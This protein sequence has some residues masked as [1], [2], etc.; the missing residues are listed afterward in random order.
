M[1]SLNHFIESKAFPEF[2]KEKLEPVLQ[3]IDKHIRNNRAL[4]IEPTVLS[5]V[6]FL[7]GLFSLAGGI[8]YME[9]GVY[10]ML[11]YLVVGIFVLWLVNHFFPQKRSRVD[12]VKS[13]FKYQ[14]I[15]PSLQ[16]AYS[17]VIFKSNQ[18]MGKATI[19]KSLLFM[20]DLDSVYGEDFFRFHINGLMMQFSEIRASKQIEIHHPGY[21]F[22]SVD[23]HKRF[24]TTCVVKQEALGN[25]SNVRKKIKTSSVDT[26]ERKTLHLIKL[27]DSLFE[28]KFVVYGEDPVETRFILSPSFMQKMV[29]LQAK[30]NKRI[31]FSFVDSRM[32]IIIPHLWDLFE[33]ES[34]PN[35]A[36]YQLLKRKLK[37]IGDITDIVS[38]LELDTTVWRNLV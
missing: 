12:V 31:E 17:N 25:L 19:K 13:L 14:V 5:A 8:S 32:Y 1:E 10:Y 2:Y 9:F 33:A 38:E 7:M 6:L 22:I 11:I 30:F 23:F 36:N 35:N 18:R 16:A 29:E 28:D 3:K 24:K 27:E 4:F 21:I 15:Y 26:A 34:T 20:N 37:R